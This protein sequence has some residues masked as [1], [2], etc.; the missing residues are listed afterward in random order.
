MRLPQDVG[1]RGEDCKR[2]GFG[3][4]I[5]AGGTFVH[6]GVELGFVLGRTQALEEGLEAVLLFFQTFQRFSVS[7]L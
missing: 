6:K 7:A 2:L 1:R 4:V 3:G 5:L